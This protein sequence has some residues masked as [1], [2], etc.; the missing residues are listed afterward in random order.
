MVGQHIKLRFGTANVHFSNHF[1]TDRGI[2]TG[3]GLNSASAQPEDMFGAEERDIEQHSE[4]VETYDDGSNPWNR[5][6]TENMLCAWHSGS[7]S[8]KEIETA[9][10]LI[11]QKGDSGEAYIFAGSAHG[12]MAV[13]I[14]LVWKLKLLLCSYVSGAKVGSLPRYRA[15]I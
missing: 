6:A 9:A 2:L 14:I 5:K 8:C 7:D 12:V 15:Y 13:E 3:W 1:L 11:C 4:C 10:V